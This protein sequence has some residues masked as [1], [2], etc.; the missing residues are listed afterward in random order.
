MLLFFCSSRRRHTSC[1]LVTGVQTCALPI[2]QCRPL[3]HR[4]GGDRGA[5]RGHYGA[6]QGERSENPQYLQALRGRLPDP[7]SLNG[8]RRLTVLPLAEAVGLEPTNGL[9][10]VWFSRPVPSTTRP[11][12]Q[13]DSAGS[14]PTVGT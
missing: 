6:V 7:P 8:T 1:A 4:Q 13:T 12:L 10:S 2:S 11:H 14:L 9:P 3:R 5:V